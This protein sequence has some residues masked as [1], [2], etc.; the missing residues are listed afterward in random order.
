MRTTPATNDLPD[1]NDTAPWPEALAATMK[2][3]ENAMRTK[4]VTY[5]LELTD[6]AAFAPSRREYDDVA[7]T[8]VD[9]PAAEVNRSFYADVGQHWNWLHR[10]DWSDEQWQAYLDAGNVETWVLTCAAARAG[11]I[12]FQRQPAGNVEIVY[13]GLLRPFTGRGLGS[14]LL[15]AAVNRAWKLGARRVWLHTCTLDDPRALGFY[16]SH[17]FALYDQKESHLDLPD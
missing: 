7:L 6:P 5:Y 16:Q 1:D 3:P 9:P 12:E 8:R 11:Y 15:A 13:F 10:L 17:G 4:I 2:R 14:L